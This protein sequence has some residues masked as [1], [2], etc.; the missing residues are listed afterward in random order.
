MPIQYA[1]LPNQFGLN[2]SFGYGNEIP[3][4]TTFDQALKGMVGQLG[5]DVGSFAT[6]PMGDQAAGSYT[7]A[8]DAFANTLRARGFGGPMPMMGD[9]LRGNYLKGLMAIPGAGTAAQTQS[10]QQQLQGLQQFPASVEQATTGMQSA[11]LR[12]R[13]MQDEQQQ[14]FNNMIQ[15]LVHMGS[16]IAFG[17]MGLGG[18]LGGMFPNGMAGMFG[19]MLSGGGALPGNVGGLDASGNVIPFTG[20]EQFPMD[21]QAFPSGPGMGAGID[22]SLMP[23]LGGSSWAGPGAGMFAGVG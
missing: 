15:G 6:T 14:Q 18:Y 19:K 23:F 2:T 21:S 10:R 4:G 12:N 5:Q 11:H 9:A 1:G 17:P 22:P 3:F 13:Q 7:G 20:N 8:S 16:Q